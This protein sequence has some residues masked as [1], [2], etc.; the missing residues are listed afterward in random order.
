MES[1]NGFCGGWKEPSN[2]IC[3]LGLDRSHV[4][5]RLFPAG[6]VWPDYLEGSAGAVF[7]I[8]VKNDTL[9]VPC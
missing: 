5:F 6:G 4:H 9:K 1:E 7:L 3:Q 2:S 8:A